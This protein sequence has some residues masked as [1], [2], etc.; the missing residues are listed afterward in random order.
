[1]MPYSPT[2]LQGALV[3]DDSSVINGT[4]RFIQRN[5]LYGR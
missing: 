2:P 4:L 5:S 3:S 1:M